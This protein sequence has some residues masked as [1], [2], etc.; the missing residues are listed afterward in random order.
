MTIQYSR[1]GT[2]RK[3]TLTLLS[4]KSTSYLHKYQIH[5]YD[6]MYSYIKEPVQKLNEIQSSSRS[7][8]AMCKALESF[9]RM[10]MY[11][12]QSYFLA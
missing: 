10:C 4:K 5:Q 3:D 9:Q 8:T 1:G 7:S 2:G 12:E 6:C 11:S